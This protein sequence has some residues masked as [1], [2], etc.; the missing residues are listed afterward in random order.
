MARRPVQ[1]VHFFGG[2]TRVTTGNSDSYDRNE[3]DSAWPLRPYNCVTF[4][5]FPR[6]PVSVSTKLSPASARA[7]WGEVYRARDRELSRD[8]ALKV[9]PRCFLPRSRPLAP[10]RTR[11]TGSS[12]AE[13][14]EHRALRR[15]RQ[16]GVRALVL[17]LVEGPRSRSTSPGGPSRSRGA[18]DCAADRRGARGSAR[19]GHR[20]SG[21]EAGQH[22][23]H[24]RT[25]WSRCS[26]SAWRRRRAATALDPIDQSPTV[27]IGRHARRLVLGHR[28]LHEPGTGTRAPV[29]KRTDIWAFGCVLFEML[30]GRPRS[31]A[32]RSA[33]P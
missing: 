21:S 11:S 32:R 23:D 1:E 13:P 8:V 22:Q 27:T 19:E 3:I 26:T 9:L 5:P 18:H 33:T 20:P 15:G 30:T 4:G 24:D 25:A 16:H 14:P 7:G 29:D 17:E 10:V 28:G 6:L 2:W 31:R 12:L